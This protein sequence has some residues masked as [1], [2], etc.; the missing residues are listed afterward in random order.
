MSLILIL[1]LQ[2]TAAVT[3]QHPSHFLVRD[4][5]E[6]TLS[7][8][9]VKGDGDECDL[10]NW[11]FT[12]SGNTLFLGLDAH[13]Q[14]GEKAKSDR[15][16]IA[17][18]CSLVIKKVTAEDVGVYTCRQIKSGQTDDA[19]VHLSV[20]TMTE[21]QGSD[22]VTFSCSVLT[23]EFCR[24]TV[25]WLYEG[26]TVDEGKKTQLQSDCSATVTFPSSYLNQKP[27]YD[28]LLK[29]EATGK[30][31]G[32]VQLF[33]FRPQSS[34]EEETTI[35]GSEIKDTPSQGNKTQ[36]DDKAVHDDEDEGDG[37]VNY[38]DFGEIYSSVP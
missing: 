15:F 25:K 8:E 20:V 26:K 18:K 17:A 4:G 7:C 36:M 6:A 23:R 16:S 24:H 19:H 13:G 2:F 21:R 33:T 12:V 9:N 1:V 32:K 5:D 27:K 37:A 22:E 35:T 14:A 29:C 28:E 38:E 10:T 31:N 30:N 3:G 34:V 11:L